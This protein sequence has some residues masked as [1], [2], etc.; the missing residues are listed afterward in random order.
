MHCTIIINAVSA[1]VALCQGHIE[2]AAG[3]GAAGLPNGACVRPC[4][5][6]GHR[7]ETARVHV[8]RLRGAAEHTRCANRVGTVQQPNSAR[9]AYPS[10]TPQR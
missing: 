6:N 9:A 8:P 7:E 3:D 1:C 4:L 10:N 5:L 2:Q